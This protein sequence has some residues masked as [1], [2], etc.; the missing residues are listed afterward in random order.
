MFVVHY[1]YRVALTVDQ[2]NQKSLFLYKL[3]PTL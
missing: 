1:G 3:K 2:K